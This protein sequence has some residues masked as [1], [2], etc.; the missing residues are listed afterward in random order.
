MGS[1]N[2]LFGNLLSINFVASNLNDLNPEF[3]KSETVTAPC[4]NNLRFDCSGKE[5]LATNFIAN[6][7]VEGLGNDNIEASIFKL[8]FVL[9]SV[10]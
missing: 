9:A 3:R 8:Y 6:S 5:D 2:F 10:K 7:V 1:E 4:E